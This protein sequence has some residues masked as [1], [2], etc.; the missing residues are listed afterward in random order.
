MK[1]FEFCLNEPGAQARAFSKAATAK[2]GMRKAAAA[3]DLT[4][5]L[6]TRT[7][8]EVK[9]YLALRLGNAK[10]FKEREYV[11][12]PDK[13]RRGRMVWDGFNIAPSQMMDLIK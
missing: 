2:E 5:P 8:E 7:P 1:F 9:L 13:P 10:V 12:I 6:G 11:E 4:C 3:M